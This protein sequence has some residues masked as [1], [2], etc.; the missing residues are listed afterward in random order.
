MTYL[1]AFVVAV[2]LVGCSAKRD[3]RLECEGW[4]KFKADT[5]IDADP[6]IVPGQQA[7]PK[8][9]DKIILERKDQ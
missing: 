3:I 2:A 4:C 8:I 5:D 6:D 7:R 1:L 9:R